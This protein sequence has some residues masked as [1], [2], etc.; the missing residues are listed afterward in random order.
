M[1][2]GR[3]YCHGYGGGGGD[4]VAHCGTFVDRSVLVS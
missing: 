2:V 1:A 3:A 4:D